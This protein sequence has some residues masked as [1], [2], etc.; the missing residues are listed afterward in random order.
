I[1]LT[2]IRTKESPAAWHPPTSPK[3]L[4]HRLPR[5]QGAQ[6]AAV[7][8]RLVDGDAEGVVDGGG[9]FLGADGVALD[10]GGC[11]VGLAVDSSAPD[12][13]AGQDGGVDLRPVLAAGGDL[14]QDL[15]GA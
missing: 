14:V 1:P 8:L 15:G 13:A 12:A 3:Q 10:G 9:Q 7:V 5:G 11:L 6:D 4:H 2:M